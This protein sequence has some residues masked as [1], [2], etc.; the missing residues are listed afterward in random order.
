M[1]LKRLHLFVCSVAR[2]SGPLGVPATQNATLVVEV[3]C[4]PWSETHVVEH[5]IF[6]SMFHARKHGQL[7]GRALS[8]IDKLEENRGKV[9]IIDHLSVCQ[10]CPERVRR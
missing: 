5:F 3:V 1:S 7:D 9:Q 2:G 6:V 10:N 4:Q 8:E